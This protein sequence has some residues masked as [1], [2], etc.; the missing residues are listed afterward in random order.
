MPPLSREEMAHLQVGHTEIS[1]PVAT[2]LVASFLF[3]I[4]AVPL[5]QA[6]YESRSSA[7]PRMASFNLWSLLSA[8]EEFHSIFSQ[9]GPLASFRA[10]RDVNAGMMKRMEE[11]EKRLLEESILGKA[12]VPWVEAGLIGGLRS[13]S[14]Q[15]YCGR[16]DWLFFRP[17]IDY[18]TGHGFLEPRVLKRRAA[19][20][21][22][23]ESPPEPDPLPAILEFRDQLKKRGIELILAPA[24][25]KGI[26][27]P[28]R[29]SGRYDSKSGAIQNPS[30]ED[31]KR[32]LAEAGISVFDSSPS[33]A[34]SRAGFS[35]PLYLATDTHWSPQGMRVVAG[36]LADFVR[37][38]RV[39]P[40]S[41]GSSGYR[42]EVA[43][44]E[45]LGDV[46]RMLRFPEGRSPYHPQ[47]VAIDQVRTS[48]GALWKAD[49][50]ADVLLL[51]DSYSNIYSL[52][53]MGWGEGAGLAEQLSFELDRPVDTILMN[54]NGSYATR[55]EL[56][57]QLASGSDRLAGK[58]LVIWEFTVRELSV[59]DWKTGIELA[60]APAT[61][62]GA[63]A[64]EL[65]GPIKA[66]LAAIARPPQPGSVP[67]KDCLIA[68]DVKTTAGGEIVVFAWGMRDNVWTPAARLAPGAQLDLS[69][70]PWSEV[71]ER[72][73]SI[74]RAEL[75]DERL[76]TLKTY[77]WEE[78]ESASTKPP[79][80][81][82]VSREVAQAA[83][84][85]KAST[86][87]PQSS[88]DLPVKFLAEL[89][90][91]SQAL[92]AEKKNTF[93][94]RDGFL[95]FGPELRSLSVG[96]FWG[97][98]ARSVSRSAKPENADPLPAILDFNAQLKAGGIELIVVPVPAK[99]TI[100][101][102]KV[103]SLVSLAAGQAPPRL[104]AAQQEFFALLTK[105]G[106]HVLDLAGEFLGGRD[107]AEGPI[108]CRQDTHW[109]PRACELAARKIAEAIK[110]RPW[111]N[112]VPKQ[113][114]TTE[115]QEVEIT[116]D[117]WQFMK[118]VSLAKEK[119]SISAVSQV[120]AAPPGRVKS[121]R[122]SPV[123]LLGDSHSLVFSAGGDMHAEGAGLMDHLAR[124]MGFA[125][126]LVA[127]RGSGAT[128]A[129]VSLLRRG[130]NLKGKRIVIWC[131]GVREFTESPGGWQKLQV[132]RP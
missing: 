108:F 68:L 105:G 102:D 127:V 43:E 120:G 66:T 47:R 12:V 42:R 85:A 95:F 125:P 24:P 50:N 88:A 69:V 5:S 132:I 11:Y 73:G 71:E 91:K 1:R 64:P 121:W 63:A 113:T 20:G 97:E 32:R 123:V 128:P 23:W 21:K 126:D 65:R 130:D 28:D 112:E 10:A 82:P 51:G 38:S 4:Y 80:A 33:L 52:G 17:G 57:R 119:V 54:D 37:K 8:G 111:I 79:S 129:R 109:S 107:A 90:E 45:N 76:L 35:E 131:F 46:A 94:G 101:P 72:Y 104:D 110:D 29:F 41:S 122:E 22:K 7:Q 19:A 114:F 70:I 81:A 116:G 118:D 115:R 15:A 56:A 16:E 106:V 48:D 6:L 93:A 30:F 55:R 9:S 78:K 99:A 14:E 26:V 31:L 124:E 27:Y 2:L 39:I 98:A 103:S 60:A 18:L 59:G 75:D 25:E 58:R 83:G 89:K 100:F 44:V 87:T 36:D 74:N 67:Y 96:P 84:D 77:W 34:S 92:E 40:P 61:L 3:L 13:G 86:A 49:R 62:P 117:L 53:S